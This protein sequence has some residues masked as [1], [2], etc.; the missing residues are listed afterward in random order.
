MEATSRA[1]RVP[2]SPMAMPMSAACSAGTSFTPSP[3]TATISPP[4]SPIS[5]ATA[6]A[7]RA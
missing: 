2:R 3:V 6:T 7:V 4:P 1:L 5:R